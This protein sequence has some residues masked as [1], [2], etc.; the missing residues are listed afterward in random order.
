MKKKQKRR[1]EQVE[2]IINIAVHIF[3]IHHR[4]EMENRK[5]KDS[6]THWSGFLYFPLSDHLQ[7]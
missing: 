5:Y 6:G 3:L 2:I 7:E 1:F 4:H